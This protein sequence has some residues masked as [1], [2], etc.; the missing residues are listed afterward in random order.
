MGSKSRCRILL[1]DMENS[2]AKYFKQYLASYEK[3]DAKVRELERAPLSRIWEMWPQD[4]ELQKVA[5][6][7]EARKIF[8]ILA[9]RRWA[10][11]SLMSKYL[12]RVPSAA[13][14]PAAS[15]SERHSCVDWQR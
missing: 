5:A 6:E 1:Y 4:S 12:P 10:S 13:V 8:A 9:K 3:A 14:A 7:D 15:D 2:L 11:L